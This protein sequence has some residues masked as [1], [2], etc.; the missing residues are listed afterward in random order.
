VGEFGFAHE[1]GTTGAAAAHDASPA[2][3][4]QVDDALDLRVCQGRPVGDDAADVRGQLG[5]GQLLLRL[6]LSFQP[7]DASKACGTASAACRNRNSARR[8]P[9]LVPAFAGAGVSPSVP[10]EELRRMAQPT[11]TIGAIRA[12]YR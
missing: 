7:C 10:L 3:A 4:Q 2:R 5:G 11:A 6:R 8:L 9:L 1:V 12:G